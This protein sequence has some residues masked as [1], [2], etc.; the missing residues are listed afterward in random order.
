MK[1]EVAY[2]LP[3]RQWLAEV[4]VPEGATAIDAARAALH[5]GDL[6]ALDLDNCALGVW[7]K[8][9]APERVLADGERVEI[10]RPLLADPKEVRRALAAVG[11]TMGG[12][13]R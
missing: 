8:K 12:K 2:A 13:R 9:V 7:S 5:A 11:K 1:V 6:P 10:Y 3:E 4:E